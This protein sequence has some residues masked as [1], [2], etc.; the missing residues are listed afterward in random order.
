[1]CYW[2][3]GKLNISYVTVLFQVILKTFNY[4]KSLFL[5]AFEIAFKI[6]QKYFFRRHKDTSYKIDSIMPPEASFY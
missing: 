3:L 1:M 5:I 6:G 4:F 2:N